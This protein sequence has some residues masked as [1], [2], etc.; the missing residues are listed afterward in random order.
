MLDPI[1]IE[2]K[3]I[4]IIQAISKM[5]KKEKIAFIE[6]LLASISPQYLD[7]IKEARS[8]YLE[9]RI[10]THKEVFGD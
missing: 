3:P 2:I 6:D 9:G 1:K 8:D 5:K 4:T 7:S 10:K